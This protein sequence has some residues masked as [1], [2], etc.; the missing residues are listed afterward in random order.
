MSVDIRVGPVG[1]SVVEVTVGQWLKGEGDTVEA[2]ELLVEL[3]TDK[4]NME[5]PADTS[6]VLQAIAKAEGET[7][8][9]GEVLGVIGDGRRERNKRAASQ[10]TRRSGNAFRP[11]KR[12]LAQQQAQTA[13]A[14]PATPTAENMAQATQHRTLRAVKGTMPGPGRIPAPAP[15]WRMTKIVS[16]CKPSPQRRSADNRGQ[17]PAAATPAATCRAA[18]P[19]PRR[20]RRA[21]PPP[22]GG[23][24]SGSRCRA[25]GKTIATRL[26]RGPA[27]GG[28]ADDLQRD[29]HDGDHGGAQAPPRRVQGA[30]RHR[31][32]LH[33][34]LHQGGRRRP[35]SLPAPVTPRFRAT[36]SS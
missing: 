7:V 24:K 16:A 19:S 11:P 4:V 5:V 12:Q 3:E 25:A 13:H 26:V 34:V 1:E 14:T 32:R 30:P 21:R 17:A 35:E 36:R 15:T 28:D 27:D 23:P 33:V 8:G 22:T 31:P 6:G 9:I 10:R 2:G 29:R 20:C 18:A